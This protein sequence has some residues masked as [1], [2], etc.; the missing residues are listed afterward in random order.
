LNEG[1]STGIAKASKIAATG[2]I[3]LR[4][5]LLHFDG[6]MLVQ[7][8]ERQILTSHCGSLPRPRELIGPLRD[9]DAGTLQDGR[10]LA[11]AV[12]KSVAD[13][14]KKQIDLG[15]DIVDDG[16]HSK[17]SFATYARGRIGGLSFVEGI[18]KRSVAPSRDEL[19]FPAVYE[20]MRVMYGARGSQG[21][22]SRGMTTLACTGPINYTG[23]EEVKADIDNL[24]RAIGDR[25]IE[26]FITAISPTN[27]ESY[28]ENQYYKT[29]E[30]YLEALSHAMNEEYRAIVDAGF[31]VQVDDPR[32]I[33]HYNRSPGSTLEENRKFMAL[34]VEAVNLSLRG[35][36][37]D[38]VRFHTCYSV[39]VA[40]R[41]HDLELKDYVDLMLRIKAQAY[42]IEAANPRHEHEW[43]VWE[44]VKLPAGK[45]LL[46]GVVSHCV[47]QVE[48]PELVAQ[49]ISRFAGVVG[50]ENVIASN[51]C[52]FATSAAGD[53]VHAEVAWAKLAALIEGARLASQRLWS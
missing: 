47:Y 22:K 31:I 15:I 51:D 43:Q 25:P 48:H 27:L 12:Q 49:R 20:E 29:Q 53:E 26:G 23:H 45:L 2:E 4:K 35:I 30:D 46:P 28:F 44:N 10:Q 13:V 6:R 9:K 40:P 32:L 39:N 37:E 33:T 19:A 24:K 8:S 16:E 42:S 3:A 5:T 17:S 18:A 52:G 1:T 50:R 41:V 11:E 34:R 36:P 38:R 14:V 7:S 21:G